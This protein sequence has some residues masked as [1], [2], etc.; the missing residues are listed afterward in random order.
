MRARPREWVSINGFMADSVEATEA[1]IEYS[2]VAVAQGTW[3]ERGRAL[4]SKAN[5]SSYCQEVTKQL[6]LNYKSP[7]F[8]V[9]LQS[10]KAGELD[11]PSEDA[12]SQDTETRTSMF[13]SMA[14]NAHNIRYA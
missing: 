8:T 3:Q 14:L 12:N 9:S 7:S 2:V 10:S 6:G 1:W 5:L 11:T 13:R 4:E